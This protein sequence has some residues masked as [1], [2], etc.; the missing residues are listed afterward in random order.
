MRVESGEWKGT[1]MEVNGG[2]KEGRGQ[3]KAAKGEN[4]RK[5]AQLIDDC[6]L[7]H[8]PCE[9]HLLLLHSL[10]L[11]QHEHSL[12]YILCLFLSGIKRSPAEIGRMCG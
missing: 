5:Y 1:V 3:S 6:F 12:C 10:S 2:G 8:S 11:N 7:P 9:T 4:G